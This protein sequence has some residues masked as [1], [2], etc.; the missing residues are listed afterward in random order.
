MFPTLQSVFISL[1][2]VINSS[3]SV[4]PT[5]GEHFI[6]FGPTNIILGGKIIIFGA[7]FVMIVIK[8]K[9]NIIRVNNPNLKMA[10]KTAILTSSSILKLKKSNGGI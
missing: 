5:T 7:L 6:I 9:G 4:D 1:C 3:N 10:E 2:A 8:K